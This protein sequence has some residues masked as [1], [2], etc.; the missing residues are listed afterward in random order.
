M[1]NSKPAFPTIEQHHT[2]GVEHWNTVPGMSL[3]EYYAVQA[4]KALLHP[5]V[6]AKLKDVCNKL[7]ITQNEYLYYIHWPQYIAKMSVE[8]ADALIKELSKPQP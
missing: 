3:R 2:N 6:E 4:M 1:D 5:D 8:Q 7:G